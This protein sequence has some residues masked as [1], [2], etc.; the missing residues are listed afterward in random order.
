MEVKTRVQ[1]VQVNRV[2]HVVLKVRDLARAER[3]YRDVLGFKVTA[4]YHEGAEVVFL[5]IDDYHHDLAI[6]EVGENAQIGR[7]HV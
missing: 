7:A 5:A 1:P 2:G 6:V 3:F 4:R